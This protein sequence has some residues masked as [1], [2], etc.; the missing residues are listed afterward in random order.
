MSEVLTMSQM[1]KELNISRRVVSAV[2]N[3][4]AD[5]LPVGAATQKRIKQYL[6]QRGYVQSKSALQIKNGA[7][8]SKSLQAFP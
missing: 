4:K 1:A 8:H 3:N 7:G 2:V 5:K 6:D